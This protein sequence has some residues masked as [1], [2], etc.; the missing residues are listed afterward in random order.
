MTRRFLAHTADL[1]AELAA[2]DLPALYSE[3]AALVREILVD[4]SEVAPRESRRVALEGDEEGER[5]FR[6][7]RELVYLADAESFLPAA[8]RYEDPF[9]VVAGERFDPA[10]HVSERAIK[11]VT[12]HRFGFERDAAG[13]RCEVVFDL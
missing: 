7:L 1:R 9:A 2:P 11:A 4:G 12:R 3:G 8:V 5:Y 6:F 10:R 13:Y